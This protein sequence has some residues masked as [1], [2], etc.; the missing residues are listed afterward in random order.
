M[1]NLTITIYDIKYV[2]ACTN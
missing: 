2:M 1:N